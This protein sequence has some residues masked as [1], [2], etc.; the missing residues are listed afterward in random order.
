MTFSINSFDNVSSGAT[1]GPRIWSYGSTTDSLVT[2]SQSGYFNDIRFRVDRNDMIFVSASDGVDQLKVTSENGETV[3]TAVYL[4]SSG[5]AP[6]NA[7]YITQTANSDLP[8]E[9]ALATLATG[10]LKNTT[11]T[12]V[13]SAAV[14]GTDYQAPLSGA[15]LTAVTV[16]TDDKVLIQDTSDSNNL[17]SVTAQSIANLAPGGS[18]VFVQ[19][20]TTL[21]S[22]QIL[23]LLNTP[24]LVAPAGGANTVVLISSLILSGVFNSV[25]YTGGGEL[26]VAYDGF[27]GIAVYEAIP[28]TAVTLQN[29]ITFPVPID[30]SN[31]VTHTDHVNKGLFIWVGGVS[32]FATGNGTLNVYVTYEIVTL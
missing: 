20:K 7:T 2:I 26:S 27:D 5:G 1:S 8:N 31:T 4:P 3:T 23:D 12:G 21:S 18:S 17:K 24:V 28:A 11:T 25:N 19:L 29:R 30:Y 14:A 13:L 10:L 32:Q 16:A 9:Q 22:A 15:T 6:N